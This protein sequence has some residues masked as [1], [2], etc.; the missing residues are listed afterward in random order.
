LPAF[1]ARDAAKL[2]WRSANGS[3]TMAT[4]ASPV[5]SM[6]LRLVKI[7]GTKAVYINKYFK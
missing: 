7:A 2:D 6:A 5:V 4:L 3:V 1:V